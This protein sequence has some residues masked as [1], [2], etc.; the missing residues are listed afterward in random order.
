[1][2]SGWRIV[3]E[4]RA[5]DAFAGE[6]A[7]VYGGRWNS[8]G[9]AVVYASQYKS[10]AALEQLVHLNPRSAKRFK[11]FSFQFPD[12]LI[13]SVAA[14]DLPKDWRQ[15]PPP[16]ST[17]QFGDAWVRQAHSAVLAVPSIIIPEEL[18]YVLNPAHTDF[19]KITIAKSQDFVFDARLFSVARSNQN[20]KDTKALTSQGLRP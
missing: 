5:G 13:D 14:R 2:A 9:L 16:P 3:P 20:H 11:A 12:T 6:G 1:M 15:E 7:K 8:P 4:S 19:R 10:L 18:N 17:Q